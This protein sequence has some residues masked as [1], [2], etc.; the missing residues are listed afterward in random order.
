VAVYLNRGI[1]RLSSDFPKVQYLTY[2]C[3]TNELE[4]HGS[5][6]LNIDVVEPHQANDKKTFSN[7]RAIYATT[8]GIW[9]IYFAIL[10]R[11]K[12]PEVSLFNSCLRTRL[13]PDQLS[14]P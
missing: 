3:D 1:Y 2:L 14:D 7:Q 8:D 5:Q 6:V 11:K 12:Y 9:V 13:T 4:L 10:D